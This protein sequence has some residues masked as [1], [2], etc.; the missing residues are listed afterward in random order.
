MQVFSLNHSLGEKFYLLVYEGKQDKIK[1]TP[2]DRTVK[3]QYS[4]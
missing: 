1:C 4:P 3:S 2:R